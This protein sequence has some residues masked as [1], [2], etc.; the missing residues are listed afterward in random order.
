MGTIPQN[1]KFKPKDSS[2]THSGTATIMA[3]GTEMRAL[4]VH[5]ASLGGWEGSGKAAGSCRG[6]GSGLRSNRDSTL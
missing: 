4:T 2:G 3:Q 1:N 6:P 5:P